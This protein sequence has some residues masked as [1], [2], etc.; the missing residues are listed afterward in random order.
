MKLHAKTIIPLVL[1]SIIL[2]LT[3]ISQPSSAQTPELKDSLEQSVSSTGENIPA[4]FTATQTTQWINNRTDYY[5]AENISK[6]DAFYKTL[7]LTT[8]GFNTTKITLNFT[9]IQPQNLTKEIE[10]WYNG[11]TPS[12]AP[13]NI[14]RVMSFTIPMS[15]YIKNF[16]IKTSIETTSPINLTWAIMN[17][18]IKSGDPYPNVT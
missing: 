10:S 9:D 12:K 6:S 8:Y 2:L 5:R 11:E 15:C 16:T 3:N 14:P 7:N 18:T 1:I 13:L 17:A 4:N